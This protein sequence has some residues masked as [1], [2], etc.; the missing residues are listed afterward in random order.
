MYEQ[1]AKWGLH[2][3]TESNKRQAIN[4]QKKKTES[5]MNEEEI[6]FKQKRCA[7]SVYCGSTSIQIDLAT[8]NGYFVFNFYKRLYRQK[9]FKKESN[10][11][12][13]S[14]F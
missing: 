14:G 4:F 3:K 11:I 8:V 1:L 10:R 2:W 13:T 9:T 6:M 5:K 7:K 12:S